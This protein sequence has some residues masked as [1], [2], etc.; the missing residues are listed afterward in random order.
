MRALAPTDE[1]HKF[2][3]A[4]SLQLCG[5]IIESRWL[6]IEG[7][8]SGLPAALLVV[9]ISWLSVL[10]LG[11]G[12]LTPAGLA[13]RA[14]LLVAAV[15]MAGAVF[16]ILEISRPMEGSIRAS[17]APLLQGPGGPRHYLTGLDAQS[18]IKGI[19]G[20]SCSSSHHLN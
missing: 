11:L 13:A 16:R 17:T 14:A 2:L 18:N 3:Q 10:F 8:Q 7:A 5:D 15:S 9:L 1:A 19:S 4:Q 6:L 20:R 12:L